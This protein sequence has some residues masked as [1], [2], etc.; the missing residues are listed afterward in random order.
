MIERIFKF[1]SNEKNLLLFIVLIYFLASFFQYS[2][3][4]NFKIT[5]FYF[6][7]P[8]IY[9][10]DEPEYLLTL[11]SLLADGDFKLCNNYGQAMQGGCQAGITFAGIKEI[12]GRTEM[13]PCF[14]QGER[15]PSRSILNALIAATF[16]WPFAKDSCLLE[17]MAIFMTLIVSLLVIFLS[18]KIM[19]YF[20]FSKK[21]IAISILALAF[22]SPFWFYSKTFWSEPY[23]SLFLVASVYCFLKKRFFASGLFLALNLLIKPVNL[24]FVVVFFIFGFLKRDRKQIIN[25]FIGFLLALPFYFL[26]NYFV[27]GD[28]LFISKANEAFGGD[29]FSGLIAAFFA[30][31]FG[32]LLT[33][34]LF[35]FVIIGF[36]FFFR[37]RPF[38]SLLFFSLLFG[39]MLFWG[40]VW[41]VVLGTGGYSFRYF[42]P[43]IPLMIIPIGFFLQE[44]K[45]KKLSLL[46]WAILFISFLINLQAALTPLLIDNPPWFLIEYLFKT[47][48]I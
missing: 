37:K 44:N 48:S 40:Q 6:G 18:L 1:F 12:A 21:T 46:F 28:P 30:V 33:F 34:P 27:F 3:D 24:I 29:V 35:L 4:S 22:A 13:I 5:G 16:I 36:Y 15:L 32:F 42:A 19:Q 23:V 17:S 25:L 14:E 47:I 43:L 26:I 7:L 9:T 38:E 11:N 20:D 39:Y 45:C 2:F 10:G 31:K 41:F 8:H